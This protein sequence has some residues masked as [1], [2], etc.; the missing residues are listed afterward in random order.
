MA[1]IVLPKGLVEK[2]AQRSRMDVEAFI[3]EAVQRLLNLDPEEE[4]ETRLE[5]AKHML[6]RAREEL[7]RGDAVQASEKLYKAVEECI[8]VLACLYDIEE[9]RRAREEGG[10]WT[11]LL[12]KAARRLSSILKSRLIIDAWSQGFD[13]HVHGFHEH[14]L[15][16]EDVEISLPVVKELVRY[17]AEQLEKE[18]KR[19]HEKRA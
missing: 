12:A 7:E 17:T 10:W 9:C 15:S 4:L 2:I 3:I 19:I 6:Q 11:R 18:M 8:K 5:I 14:G 1:T 16:K 13:L